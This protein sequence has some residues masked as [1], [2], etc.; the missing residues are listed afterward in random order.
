[1]FRMLALMLGLWICLPAPAH[2]DQHARIEA[3]AKTIIER[4]A[5]EHDPAV[6]REVRALLKQAS[7]R[8]ARARR[9]QAS[10]ETPCVGFARTIYERTMVRQAAHAEAVRRCRAPVFMPAVIL[11]FE[12]YAKTAVER[13]AFER[14]LEHARARDLRGRLPFLK[15]VVSVFDDTRTQQAAL[16]D[17]LIFVDAVPRAAEACVQTSHAESLRTMV[18]LAALERAR[19]TCLGT[20]R[21]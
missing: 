17:G 9:A 10:R 21:R 18:S 15:F 4:A 12:T 8:L 5:Q 2:A 16:R 7:N 14:A 20:D 1:M 11:L 19:A 3:L 6:L 13:A